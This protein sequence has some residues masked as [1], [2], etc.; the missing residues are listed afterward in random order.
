M[1]MEMF[2]LFCRCVFLVKK[3]E[4][5][6]IVFYLNNRVWNVLDKYDKVFLYVFVDDFNFN[7]NIIWSLLV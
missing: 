6:S 4:V 2:F 3:G 1:N 7:K 5:I